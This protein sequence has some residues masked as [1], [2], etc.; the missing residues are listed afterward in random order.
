[1]A[2]AGETYFGTINSTEPTKHLWVVLTTSNGIDGEC[3]LVNF[4]DEKNL[5]PTMHEFKLEPGQCNHPRLQAKVS[6]A[7]FREAQ[8][9]SDSALALFVR[10]SELQASVKLDD[11]TLKDLQQSAINSDH[12]PEEIELKIRVFLGVPPRP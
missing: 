2:Q 10:F 6:V 11:E 1:M 12:I 8:S 7:Y 3:V 9:L 4:T 5:K